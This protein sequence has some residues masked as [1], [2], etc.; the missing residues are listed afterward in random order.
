M[1]NN[2]EELYDDLFAYRFLLQDTIDNELT[3]IKE[4]KKYLLNRN[5]SENINQ[6]I[7]DFY[8][9]YNIDMSY[10]TIEQTTISV[11]IFNNVMITPEINENED[12][13]N[14]N[15]HNSLLNVL[16]SIL[17]NINLNHNDDLEDVVVTMNDDDIANLE[18][19]K[20]TTKLPENC[21]IC[22][23]EMDE[24]NEVIKLKCLHHFHKDCIQEYLKEYNYKCPLCRTE[25]GKPK[26]NL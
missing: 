26:Y 4:L 9:K 5:I 19:I 2:L 8:K 11:I 20:L 1:S 12:Q 17:S 24:N 15:T 25:A 13:D 21:T 23:N 6:I 3:I 18:I 7:F 10:E 14:I 16:N 22:L